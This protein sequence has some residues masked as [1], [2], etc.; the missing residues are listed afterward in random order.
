MVHPPAGP[1]VEVEGLVALLQ[2][3]ADGEHGVRVIF[4][5]GE[6][7]GGNIVRPFRFQGVEISQ[8]QVRG[9]PGGLAVAVAPVGGE[10]HVL[11]AGD[12]GQAVKGACPDDKT[13]GCHK[14]HRSFLFRGWVYDSTSPP[15]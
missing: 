3:V 11:R 15:P 5:H 6:G 12:D 14:A 10:D 9:D 7:V 2:A 1:A 4:F 13:G 8:Q